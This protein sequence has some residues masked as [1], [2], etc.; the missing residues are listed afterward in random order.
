MKRLLYILPLALALGSCSD[1]FLNRYP[2]GQWHHGNFKPNDSIDNSILS[3]GK[4]IQAYDNFKSFGFCYASAALNNYITPDG[5]K[6]GGS[7]TDGGEGAP[8][9]STMS[10]TSSTNMFKLYYSEMYNCIYKCNEGIAL[11]Q[12]LVG[13]KQDKRNKLLAEALF[14]RSLAYFKLIQAFGDVPYVDKVLS[15]G[16]NTPP[17]SSKQEIYA[18]LEKDLI[19][20]TPFLSTREMNNISGNK[21]RA[22]QNAARA[23]LA[24][25]YLYQQQWNSALSMTQAIISSGD[26]NLTTPF[27]QIFKEENEFGPES[28]LEINAEFKPE[29]KIYL[30]TQNTQIQ[31]IRGVPNVGWGFNCPGF[32]LMDA[33]EAADP[34]KQVTVIADGDTFDGKKVYG[35]GYHTYW[36]GKACWNVITESRLYGRSI[37]DQGQWKNIMLIRYADIL[38]MHAEAALELGNVDDALNKI[39]QIRSRARGDQNDVLPIVEDRDVDVLRQKIRHERRIELAMEYER[40]F[41]LVRWGIAKDEVPGFVTGKHELFPIPQTEIDKSNGILTQ[42]P[43]Y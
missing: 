36:N 28:V 25:I 20:S 40:Y 8:S 38:L 23:L 35:D 7:L 3:E 31:G 1:D 27:D 42:N 11:A 10:F 33:F 32:E 43:N 9:F 17:R 16:E 41:D 34:R 37:N 5:E 2:K 30:G 29:E 4:I 14:V 13:D 22:T 15:Q 24:K 21:G 39:E 19:W 26:N 6:G 18:I 12:T